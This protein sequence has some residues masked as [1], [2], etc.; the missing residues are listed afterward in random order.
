MRSV[1]GLLVA[2]FALA[3]AGAIQPAAA[4]SHHTMTVHRASHM[5]LIPA[6]QR[7]SFRGAPGFAGTPGPAV[8]GL[9]D[10]A[11][12]GFFT[13]VGFV[14]STTGLA[15][16]LVGGAPA[17]VGGTVGLG[18]GLTTAVVGAGTGIVGTGVGYV[19][20]PAR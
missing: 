3:S 17:L 6:V 2:G 18:T 14:S 10:F 13:P 5:M 20:P 9:V 19:I 15:T 7:A 11:P 8:P 12:S 16:D 4:Y 1:R